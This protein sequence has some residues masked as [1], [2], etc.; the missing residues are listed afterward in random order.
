MGVFGGGNIRWAC[1]SASLTV[2][3]MYL[4]VVHNSSGVNMPL[5]PLFWICAS[6]VIPYV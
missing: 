2:L 4:Y 3:G 1:C 5:V 6:V